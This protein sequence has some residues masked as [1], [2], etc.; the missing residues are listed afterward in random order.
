VLEG[1]LPRNKMKLVEA[2]ME[3]HADDLMANW[4][5]AVRGMPTHKI[6]PLQ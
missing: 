1:A 6:S 4:Q 5:L 3:L 2:W